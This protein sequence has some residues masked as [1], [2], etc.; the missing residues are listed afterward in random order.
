MAITR[1]TL[2]TAITSGDTRR[3]NLA[4]T[5]GMLVN[6]RIVIG[7]EIME[8]KSVPTAGVAAVQRGIGGTAPQNHGVGTS[9]EFGQ[10]GD[11]G[12]FGA[13][14]VD[15]GV[16]AGGGLASRPVKVYTAAGEIQVQE[17]IHVLDGTVV[18]VMTL[19]LPVADDDGKRLVIV[20]NGVA[21][22]TV[23]GSYNDGDTTIATY[24][25]VGDTLELLAQ[26]GQWLIVGNEG[27]V[28]T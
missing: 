27:V 15:Q 25:L 28:M 19:Q 2:L 13:R 7:N 11:F 12:P 20:Q 24:S 9:A 5:T 21:A 22:H 23:T 6:D 18:L 14:Q 4:S 17:G 10:A 8:V 26:G 1:T 16:K 3:V